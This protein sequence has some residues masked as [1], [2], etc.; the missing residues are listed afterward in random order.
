MYR[1][2]PKMDAKNQFVRDRCKDS[3]SGGSD[4]RLSDQSP[5]F[6]SPSEES[7]PRS[8]MTELIT[9]PVTSSK[10]S[11]LMWMALARV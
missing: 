8:W 6:A 3:H 11:A 2:F 10:I 9:I 1:Y 7:W 4:D 5:E